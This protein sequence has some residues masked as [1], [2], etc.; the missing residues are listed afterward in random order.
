[1]FSP[2]DPQSVTELH[3][4]PGSEKTGTYTKGSAQ[5]SL[6]K[7][8]YVLSC[9]HMRHNTYKLHPF[10]DQQSFTS[11]SVFS[12]LYSNVISDEGAESLAAVLPHMASLTDLE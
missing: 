5:T 2:T 12:S 3:R 1:M 11:L 9:T 4:R 8:D 7:V 10:R 6:F